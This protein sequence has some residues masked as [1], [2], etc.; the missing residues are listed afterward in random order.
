V[1]CIA[2]RRA[3]LTNDGQV[4]READVVFQICRRCLEP[5][6]IHPPAITT[7]FARSS[8]PGYVFIEAFDVGEVRRSVAGL[9]TVVDKQPRS[10][11]PTEY[12]GLLSRYSPSRIEHGRWVCCLFGRYRGDLGYVCQL[13]YWRAIVAFVPRVS[14]PRGKRERNGRPPPRAWPVAE[15][16][17]QF[18]E[19]VKVEEPNVFSFRGGTYIDNLVMIWVP[20]SHLRTLDRPPGNITPFVQSTILRRDPLFPACLKRFAQEST[21]VGDRILVLS[22]EHAGIIGRVE[23]IHDNVADVVT[24][25]PEQHSGLVICVALS[26]VMPHFLAG[27]HVKDRWSDRVGIVVAAHRSGQEV[28]I[29]TKETNEVVC[30]SFPICHLPWLIFEPVDQHA[31]L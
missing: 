11:V 3:P 20:L 26:D 27:D 16:I 18:G 25:S 13:D 1:L 7:A 17:Q 2:R 15:M 6:E 10:I 12:M 8:I 24:Q 23:R 30:L 19:K 28:T 31:D 14:Q 29:L 4:G 21:Q 22:G 5:S 9:I